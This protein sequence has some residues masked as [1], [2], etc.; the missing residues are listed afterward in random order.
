MAE[1]K[2]SSLN[3]VLL[4]SERKGSFLIRDL[5]KK[6]HLPELSGTESAILN[7]ESSDSELGTPRPV[8]TPMCV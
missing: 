7:R 4:A 8:F 2:V 5:S 1:I 6:V 3:P